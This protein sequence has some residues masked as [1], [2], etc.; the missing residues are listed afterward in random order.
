MNTFR[1]RLACAMTLAISACAPSAA[2]AKPIAFAD[3]TTVMAEYGAGTMTEVR[4]M[5]PFI[6]RR[7]FAG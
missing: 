3:G 6:G 5:K 2:Q 1:G 4:P 7:R